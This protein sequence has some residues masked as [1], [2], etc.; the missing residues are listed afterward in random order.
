MFFLGPHSAVIYNYKSNPNKGQISMNFLSR[1]L[2]LL[3]RGEW[4]VY[5]DGFHFVRQGLGLNARLNII[6]QRITHWIRPLSVWGIPYYISVEPASICNLRCPV[7]PSGLNK[8]R[9]DPALLPLENFK[10]LIDQIGDYL[11][12]LQLWEWGE[13]FLNPNFYEMVAY[14]K[15]K[16]IVLITSTNGHFFDSTEAADRLMRSGLDGVIL[17][18]DGTTQEVYEQYR[19]GGDLAKVLRGI[20]NLV[21]AKKELGIGP[22]LHFRMVINAYNEHQIEDFLKLGQSL[23]VDMVSNKKINC[24]MGGEDDN[25]SILPQK[26]DLVR[27]RQ[28]AGFKYH[29]TIPWC[30]PGLMSNGQIALCA[31]A[32]QGETCLEPIDKAHPFRQIWQSQAAREF[33]RNMKNDQ[34]YYEF[35]R[36]CDCREP[37]FKEARFNINV[38][39]DANHTD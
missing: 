15:E 2:R 5:M 8:T 7:C 13:P 33:R 29:C 27:N 31:L 23:G 34:D 17:A 6:L 28:E 16:G 22:V 18:V 26:E 11:V 1:I 37:D 38:L 39:K 36:N 9:R 24:H 3:L 25:P 14:A 30:N 35:C 4:D 12:C 20:A 21:A 10:A 19:V 32:A